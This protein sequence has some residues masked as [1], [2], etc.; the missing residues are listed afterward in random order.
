MYTYFV[1][2]DLLVELQWNIHFIYTGNTDLRRRQCDDKGCLLC[3]RRP[4]REHAV[5]S[6][7]LSPCPGQ[8]LGEALCKNFGSLS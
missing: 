5:R 6:S 3:A 2:F 4:A 7:V 1:V 8:V